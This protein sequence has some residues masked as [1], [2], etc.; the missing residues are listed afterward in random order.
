MDESRLTLLR[1]KLAQKILGNISLTPLPPELE[2]I[3]PVHLAEIKRS[4]GMPKFFIFGYPRS[5]TTLLMRLVSLHPRVHCNREAHFF[6]RSIDA[7]RIFS[8]KEIRQWLE[9]RSN[10][11][12]SGQ[13][14]ETPLL[15][16]IADYIMEREALRL[17]KE[18]V[19]DKTPN[20][21]GGQAVRRL[22]AVYPDARLIYIVRDGRDAALSHRFQHFIDHPEFLTRADRR[23][24]LDFAKDSQPFL[25]QTRSVFSEKAIREEA[26]SWSKNVTETHSLGQELFRECYLSLRYEDLL[27][28]PFI[29]MQSIWSFLQVE[30][31]FSHVARMV[32]EKLNYNPGA[33]AQQKKE[34]SLALHIPRGKPGGWQELF[35]ARDKM[36]FK[37]YASETLIDWNYEQD[38]SW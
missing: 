14:L 38:A 9:K 24:R 20:T 33:E 31:N 1:R 7:T 13:A 19:G 29:C 27:Q 16:L 6:T 28:E 23:I 8:D 26:I 34:G 21:N 3:S 10:R 2:P 30:Q 37:Q 36:I 32:E 15:R 22:K 25:S 35:T 11:W 18:V 5:G 17:G 12:T 4:F